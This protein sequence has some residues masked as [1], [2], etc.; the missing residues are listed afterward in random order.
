MSMKT[1]A[2]IY[3]ICLIPIMPYAGETN[4]DNT[5]KDCLEQKKILRNI[6]GESL[7][8]RKKNEEIRETCVE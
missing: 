5:K 6:T 4:A 1:K 8:D 7:V 2:K 3:K